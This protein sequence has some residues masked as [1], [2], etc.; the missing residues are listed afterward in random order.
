[1]P[2]EVRCN[3]GH[4]LKVADTWAGRTGRCPVC[5]AL[6]QVPAPARTPAVE[7]PR[8][9]STELAEIKD[10]G[11]GGEVSGS[12]FEVSSSTYEVQGPRS[13]DQGH[14]SDVSRPTLQVAAPKP[15]ALPPP[16]PVIKAGLGG[17]V[18]NATG[19]GVQ[20]PLIRAAVD[21]V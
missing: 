6:V 15:P 19:L 2:I 11:L 13:K 7:G 9:G 20:A 5:K 3:A 1:M 16:L 12:K 4:T 14:G 17:E 8:S 10:Q 21:D 18:L